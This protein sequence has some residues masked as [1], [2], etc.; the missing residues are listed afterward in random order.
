M[1]TA[2]ADDQSVPIAAMLTWEVRGYSFVMCGS[3]TFWNTIKILMEDGSFHTITKWT[4]P[5]V[6]D[7]L[8]A[9]VV[10]IGTYR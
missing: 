1:S 9:A 5:R 2:K 8:A 6:G 10:S 3:D 4:T 7:N